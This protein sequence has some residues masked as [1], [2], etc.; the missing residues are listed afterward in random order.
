MS[1][2]TATRFC[3]FRV[4]VKKYQTCTLMHSN[5]LLHVGLTQQA[6][7]IPKQFLIYD[8]LLTLS[9]RVELAQ[10]YSVYFWFH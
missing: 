5:W 1:I 4:A 6:Y 8:W 3:V 7:I 2:S 9:L 10:H